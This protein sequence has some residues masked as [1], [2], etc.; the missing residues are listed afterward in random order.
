MKSAIGGLHLAR[1]IRAFSEVRAA[2]SA[3]FSTAAAIR[4]RAAGSARFSSGRGALGHGSLGRQ[5]GVRR[6]NL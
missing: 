2:G 3:R 6:P 4:V 5:Y 1:R